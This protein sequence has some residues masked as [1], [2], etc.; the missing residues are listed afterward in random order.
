[1]KINNKMIDVINDLSEKLKKEVNSEIE[2]LVINIYEYLK[3]INVEF[4]FEKDISSISYYINKDG[5]HERE[6]EDVY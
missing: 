4:C 3:N 1:M 2:E 5:T 6:N